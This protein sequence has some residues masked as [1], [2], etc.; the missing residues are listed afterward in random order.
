MP[1]MPLDHRAHTGPCENLIQQPSVGDDMDLVDRTGHRTKGCV[2][3][4]QDRS[5]Q[6]ATAVRVRLLKKAK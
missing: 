3:L 1:L 6:Y 2:D 5:G 4:G